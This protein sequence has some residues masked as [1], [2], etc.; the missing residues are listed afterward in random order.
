MSNDS[1][2]VL[3]RGIKQAITWFAAPLVV[4]FGMYYF[5]SKAPDIVFE[6]FPPAHYQGNAVEV[7][8]YNVAVSNVGN[9]EASDV[10]VHLT[11]PPQI[12]IQEI[13]VNPSSA[14][15][16]YNVV[17]QNLPNKMQ[18][19]FPLLNP[20][21]G[22]RF[23]LLVNKGEDA[24]LA[25]EVRGTGAI[26]RPNDQNRG[27][28]F[29]HFTSIV[30]IV[31]VMVAMLSSLLAAKFNQLQEFLRRSSS[32]QLQ[33][34]RTQVPTEKASHELEND[35]SMLLIEKKWLFNFKPDTGRS[36]VMRFGPNGLIVEG[37]NRNEAS[38]RIQ[39][40]NLEFLDSDSKVHNRFYFSPADKRFYSTNDQELGA[41]TKHGIADQYLM[42]IMIVNP[43]FA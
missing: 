1:G 36:K 34:I 38:W 3:W 41:I 39:S 32:L 8:I 21:E 9:K 24:E 37:A 4:A 28:A 10:R 30:A 18:V 7:S 42:P 27:W 16:E 22:A 12:G 40:N 5:T 26:G 25:V 13:Q 2:S 19:R 33:A 43:P 35:L 23:T 31:A 11:L 17:E 14:A 15:V 20:G 29:K 6:E